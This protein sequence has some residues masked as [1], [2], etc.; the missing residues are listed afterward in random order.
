[1]KFG[2]IKNFK[3]Q[4]IHYSYSLGRKKAYL[5][6]NLAKDLLESGIATEVCSET[7]NAFGTCST[8]N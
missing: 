5:M 2:N 1:M 6:Q 7:K 4:I 8:K 3:T